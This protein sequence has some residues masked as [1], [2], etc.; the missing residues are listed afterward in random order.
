[1][2]GLDEVAYKFPT[3]QVRKSFFI[4]RVLGLMCEKPDRKRFTSQ[5]FVGRNHGE[6][7]FVGGP[8]A[9]RTSFAG[10]LVTTAAQQEIIEVGDSDGLRPLRQAS[11]TG[12]PRGRAMLRNHFGSVIPKALPLSVNP[13]MML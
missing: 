2:R 6:Q 4:G 3:F 12:F 1:V 7:A 13:L 5:A 8:A 9:S 10:R 11:L